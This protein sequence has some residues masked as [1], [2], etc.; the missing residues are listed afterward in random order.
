MPPIGQ[1]AVQDQ[2][3]PTP[4]ERPW[5]PGGWERDLSPQDRVFLNL[6]REVSRVLDREFVSGIRI[7]Q[8][9]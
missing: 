8:P 3:P 5:T 1:S 2:P 4:T 9:D 7:P 6:T